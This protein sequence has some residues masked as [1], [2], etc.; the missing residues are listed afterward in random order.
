MAYPVTVFFPLRNYILV[1]MRIM[2]N[3]PQ[4]QRR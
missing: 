3:N 4:Y 2:Q 1:A